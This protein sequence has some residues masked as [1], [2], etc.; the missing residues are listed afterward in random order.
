MAGRTVLLAGATLVLGMGGPP[1]GLSGGARL[2]PFAV[3]AVH[4]E[5]NATEGD[6]EVVF[7]VDGGEEGLAKLSVTAPD[8]RAVID[9]TSAGGTGMGIRQ[10]RL[11]SPEPSNPELVRTA[12]PAG[13]YTFAG[14]TST[15]RKLQGKATLTHKLPGAPTLLLPRGSAGVVGSQGMEITWTAAEGMAAQILTLEQEESGESITA[16]LPGPTRT[17]VVPSGFLRAGTAY[18]IGL[19]VVAPGGNATFVEATFTARARKD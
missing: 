18:K 9:F 17:F 4:M 11:E 10:F 3:A 7:E 2:A 8:G 13:V 1:A 12:Y 6:V 19:G 14:A 15:G 16:R 5:Q